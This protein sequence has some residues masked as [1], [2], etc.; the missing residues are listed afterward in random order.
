MSPSGPYVAVCGPGVAVARESAWAEEIGRRLAE[1]GAIV[2]CG[3]MTGVM[4]DVARGAASAG[5]TVV[6]ILPGPDR[7]GASTHLT[8][9]LPTGMGETRNALVV[10]ASDVVIAVAGEW[11]TLS[12][13]A[14]ALKIGRPVV[15]LATWELAKGGKT[16]DDMVRVKTPEEAVARAIELAR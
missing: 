16:V 2:V 12:E 8:V 9:S 4:D 3:G 15:G 1:A 5:G 6:G 13:I 7:A 14:L 11:G 10:R